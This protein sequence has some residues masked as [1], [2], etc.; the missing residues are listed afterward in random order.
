VI[1]VLI[2][3]KVCSFIY[4]LACVLPINSSE[5]DEVCFP[6][7]GGASYHFASSI[8]YHVDSSQYLAFVFWTL[9][10]MLC[11]LW[12]MA[13]LCPREMAAWLLLVRQ[14]LF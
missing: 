12:Y 13:G 7:F 2:W 10:E 11:S 4:G 8:L 9:Q 6:V 3:P 5:F 1:D 14:R